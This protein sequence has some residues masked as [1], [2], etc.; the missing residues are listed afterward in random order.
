[1][2]HRSM[3]SAWSP[4]SRINNVKKV[5]INI[6]NMRT[7]NSSA[8][9]SSSHSLSFRQPIPL[10]RNKRPR[11]SP[12]A[13]IFSRDAAA[14]PRPSLRQPPTGSRPPA[15]SWRP[16][17]Q[18]STIDRRQDNDGQKLPPTTTRQQEQQQEHPS[19]LY[20]ILEQ[21]TCGSTGSVVVDDEPSEV[22]YEPRRYG[23]EST[24][25]SSSSMLLLS[26]S[27]S[28]CSSPC[29]SRAAP[30]MS[31]PVL[32]VHRYRPQD[33]EAKDDKREEP[34]PSDGAAGIAA[35]LKK[36]ESFD[37][38]IT[39]ATSHTDGSSEEDSTEFGPL[40][41]KKIPSLEDQL[42][43]DGRATPVV[44]NRSSSIVRR[45]SCEDNDTDED[46]ARWSY[47]AGIGPLQQC[48]CFDDDDVQE[49]PHAQSIMLENRSRCR[50]AMIM[51]TH[52]QS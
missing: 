6:N 30:P 33:D 40:G 22:S 52:E 45:R 39:A 48:V 50:L 31:P 43:L 15:S 47:L 44:S 27:S 25:S 28:T 42:Q 36:V 21:F 51:M 37:T 1:M 29:S 35:A 17:H 5:P 2:H 13:G 16:H 14:R 32:Y 24:S 7:I 23:C 20:T 26:T 34:A 9:P 41:K 3:K 11:V 8:A 4:Q 18:S 19:L 12:N 38:E 46:D 49:A 10:D